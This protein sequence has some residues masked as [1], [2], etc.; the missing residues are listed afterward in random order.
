M[1]E[2]LREV[3]GGETD[4]PFR[5]IEAEFV[6]H[7][8]AQPGID[9]RRRR[10]HAFDEAAQDD[11]VG[12][13]QARFELTENMEL[14]VGKLGPPHHPFG[15]GGLKQLGIVGKRRHQPDALLR[16]RSDRRKRP[17]ARDLP[18]PSNAMATP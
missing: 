6:A 14:C 8:P 3:M 18:D 9:A 11:A 2:Q 12:L 13:R 7:R 4:A 17:Q 5:Q 15:K 1:A 16:G 10:P